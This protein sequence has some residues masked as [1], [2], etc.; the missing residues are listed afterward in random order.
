MMPQRQDAGIHSALENTEAEAVL[1]GA[2][3]Q[4]NSKVY[5]ISDKLAPD[6][7]AEAIHGRIY[8]AVLELLASGKSASPITMAPLFQNDEAMR[9]LGGPAYLAK[10]TGS[11]MAAMVPVEE[12]ADQILDLAARRRLIDALDVTTNEAAD[13]STPLAE[14]I[15]RSDAA[16]VAAIERRETWAQPTAGEAVA[17]AIARI[18]AIKANDGKVGVTTGISELDDLL[19]G[20]EPGQLVIVAAR[21]GMGKTAVAC[22][23]ARGMAKQGE[24][25]LFVSLEMKADELGMRIASDHCFQNGRGVPFNAIVNARI[26]DDQMRALIRAENE[27]RTYPL[28]IIDAGSVTMSR[29]ALGVRRNKRRMAAKG[30]ELKVVIIDYLQLLQTDQRSKSVYEAVSE[31]S[32]GLK[33]L[34]KDA[35]VAI[36]ALAQL[37]RGVEGR[38]NKIPVLSDLRDSGQIEQD[39]DAIIF[40]HR[41]EYYLERTKPKPGNEALHEQSLEACRNRIGYFCAKRRNGCVGDRMGWYLPVYQAVR[42]SDQMGALL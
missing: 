23:A 8:H 30:H 4:H 33:A 1:L 9:Q 17:Q 19:G 36:V 29:L 16:L 26:T 5:L 24:G 27:I 34:A 6:D 14:I 42:G 37:N 13:C 40:L 41:E 7:F 10:L 35:G 28:N 38:E 32:R 21:P 12:F 22:S 39:A 11:G 2:I 3:M 15:D 18:E 20:F 31:I 25:V